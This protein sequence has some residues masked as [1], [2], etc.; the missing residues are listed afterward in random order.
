MVTSST[1]NERAGHGPL[2]VGLIGEGGLWPRLA[3]AADACV[4]IQPVAY[5][6]S[7]AVA[8]PGQMPRYDDPRQLLNHPGLEAVI[9]AVSTRQDVELGQ[10]AAERGLHVWRCGPLGRNFA[11]GVEIVRR[12]RQVP[13]V[14]RVASWWEY[15]VDHVWHELRWPDVFRVLFSELRAATAGPA[16]TATRAH[17]TEVAGGALADAG[18]NLLEALVGLRGLPSSVVGLIGAVASPAGARD[19]EELAAALLR[20]DDGG[21][22][23]VRAAW[24]LRLGEQHLLHQGPDGCVVLTDEEVT[25]LD[26]GGELVERRPL[27]ADYWVGELS[28]FAELVRSMARDRAVAPLERHLAVSALLE[29]IYLAA[30]T[31]HPESPRKLYQV[32]GRPEPQA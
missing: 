5:S 23:L 31:G 20:Y 11:E 32:Q 18:Y 21:S 3:A 28:R 30:R 19:T 2:R 13:T 9:L 25:L 26:A 12:V 22:A 24:D 10:L 27:P 14:Y 15:V 4:L 16:P 6:S 7:A 8:P 1:D 17:L 29:T